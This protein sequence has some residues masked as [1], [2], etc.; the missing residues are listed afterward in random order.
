[1]NPTHKQHRHPGLWTLPNQA[2]HFCA[3]SDSFDTQ[4]L[5]SALSDVST[6]FEQ[7]QRWVTLIGQPSNTSVSHVLHMLAQAGVNLRHV[8]WIRPSDAASKAFAAEQAMLLDN[9]AL[10]VAWLDQCVQRDALR[11]QLA[12]KHTQAKVMIYNDLFSPIALH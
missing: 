8:R 9:S 1:M 3:N 6:Q 7:H 11:L 5:L 2:P 4:G 12:R 10:V